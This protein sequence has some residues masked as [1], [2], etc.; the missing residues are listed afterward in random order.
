MPVLQRRR[1]PAPARGHRL[2][3][4]RCGPIGQSLVQ[5]LPKPIKPTSSH[6]MPIR[7]HDGQHADSSDSRCW[8]LE[9]FV[10]SRGPET[11]VAQEHRGTSGTWK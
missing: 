7:S 4:D 6:P 11:I 2:V 1:D 3:V 9:P 5:E 8:A 10:A